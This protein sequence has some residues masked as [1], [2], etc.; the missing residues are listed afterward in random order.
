MSN[1][2]CYELPE[3]DFDIGF[4]DEIVVAYLDEDEFFATLPDAYPN[5]RLDDFE[6]ELTQTTEIVGGLNT[7]LGNHINS[8]NAHTKE[9]LEGL[10]LADFPEFANVNITT[11]A[12]GGAIPEAQFSYLGATAKSV[13][14][15]L[16]K[17]IDKLFKTNFP[18][19]LTKNGTF[20]LAISDMEQ[21][22]QVNSGTDC[23]CNIPANIDVA[24]N[25]GS[26]LTIQQ[27][28]AGIVTVTALSGVTLYGDP[29][30]QGQYKMVALWKSAENTW[31]VIGGTA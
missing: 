22:V 26:I 2:I 11:L 29:K 30:T 24:F 25:I 31:H 7:A 15:F 21:V 14:S 27:V 12:S 20:T 13:L 23:L 18:Q 5:Q 10:K 9:N 19:P 8:Q 4:T 6:D 16:S 3:P 17:I 28:G 1:Y